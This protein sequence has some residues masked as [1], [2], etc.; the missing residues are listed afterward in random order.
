MGWEQDVEGGMEKGSQV[1]LQKQT[2]NTRKKKKMDH[3]VFK[4]HLYGA[5]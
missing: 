2:P 1:N 3:H 4:Y 5:I